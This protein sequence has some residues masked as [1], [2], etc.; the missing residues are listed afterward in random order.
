MNNRVQPS[1]FLIMIIGILIGIVF[2]VPIL[3][4]LSLIFIVPPIILLGILFVLHK[5]AN[6]HASEES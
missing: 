6:D 3:G 4:F 5:Q 2:L 1:T